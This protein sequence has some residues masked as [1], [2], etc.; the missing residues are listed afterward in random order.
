[1]SG[2]FTL[3]AAQAAAWI[4]SSARSVCECHCSGDPGEGVLALLGQQLA[5]CGPEQLGRVCP[6]PPACD[7]LPPVAA[8]VCAFFAGLSLGIV[9]AASALQRLRRPPAAFGAAAAS[10]RGSLSSSPRSLGNIEGESPR[11]G[12]LTPS[13]K[14]AAGLNGRVPGAGY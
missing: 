7:W 9:G 12:P 13:A 4:L 2:G 8:L 6:A 3:V 1:M 10:A 5:R 14:R 11:A